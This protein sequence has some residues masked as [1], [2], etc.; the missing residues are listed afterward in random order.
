MAQLQVGDRIRVSNW[1]R[2]YV[3]T[4]VKVTKTKAIGETKRADGTSF[5]TEFSRYYIEPNW[6]YP[7]RRERYDQT[8]RVLIDNRV[9]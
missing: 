6:I 5:T 9:E 2:T 7:F 1:F 3:S 8:K 4:I